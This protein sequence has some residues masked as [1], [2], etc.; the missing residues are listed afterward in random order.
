MARS[1]HLLDGA[2]LARMLDSTQ[3][4]I[5]RFDRPGCVDCGALNPFFAQLAGGLPDGS[6]YV[7]NCER[8]PEICDA[9]GVSSS[10]DAPAEPLI[11]AWTGTG[12]VT[13][14]G[15]RS[16]EAVVNW[17]HRL[18]RVWDEAEEEIPPAVAARA[19]AVG[20]PAEHLSLIHI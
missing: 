15:E 19:T 11:K 12:F 10:S 9:C 3:S 1:P 17:L 5:I 14:R 6:V 16:T 20:M 7:A 8:H 4:A 13:F 2:S 18:D